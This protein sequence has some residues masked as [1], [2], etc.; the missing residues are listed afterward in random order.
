LYQ[1]TEMSLCAT[2]PSTPQA[3]KVE[4]EEEEEAASS[5]EE[6]A[7]APAAA[8]AQRGSKRQKK[9]SVK[10]AGG[11]GW[12]LW[13]GLSEPCVAWLPSHG[14]R[15][16][17]LEHTCELPGLSSKVKGQYMFVPCGV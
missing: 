17:T 9:P 14:Y 10:A 16:V 11:A 5:E 12:G 4:S 3:A 13:C 8:E 7:P 1:F 6:E 2:R 15:L